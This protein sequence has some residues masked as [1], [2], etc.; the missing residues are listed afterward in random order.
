MS[1]L[2]HIRNANLFDISGFIPFIINNHVYGCVR[3]SFAERLSQWPEVFQIREQQLHLSKELAPPGVPVAERNL[4]VAEVCNALRQEGLIHGW[5][6][7]LYPLCKHWGTAPVLLLE[8][9]AI[10]YF[11]V[12]AY[13]VHMNG[14]VGTGDEQKMWIARRSYTKPTGPGKL[15]QMVAGGQPHGISLRANMIKECAE[16][17]GIPESIAKAVRPVGTLSYILE[18][19]VGLRPDIIF[20]FDLELPKDFQPLNTDGEVEAFYCQEISAVMSTIETGTEF[21]FNCALVQIDFLIRHGH[22]PADHPDYA[23]LCNGLQRFAEGD[24]GAVLG[25]KSLD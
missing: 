25:F 24:L 5:R 20:N 11:G 13:G 2:E 10:P 3:H 14:F 22:I 18:A 19:E 1:Y 15:D 21:K 7:E 6:D 12:T 16:E 9:A 4:A 8:R 17:A 23:A